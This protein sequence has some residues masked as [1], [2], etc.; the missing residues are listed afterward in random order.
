MALA[1]GRVKDPRRGVY[2]ELYRRLLAMTA[3]KKYHELENSGCRK[4]TNIRC[5]TR[6]LDPRVRGVTRRDSGC[7]PACKPRF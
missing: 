6:E 1:P 5:I 3:K 7:P 4:Y 2:P